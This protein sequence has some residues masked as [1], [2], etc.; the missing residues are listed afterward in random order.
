MEKESSSWRLF[1]NSS[2]KWRFNSIKS[3]SKVNILI[4]ISAQVKKQ[5]IVPFLF[6][7]FFL[8]FIKLK[9]LK[10]LKI[11]WLNQSCVQLYSQIWSQVHHVLIVPKDRGSGLRLKSPIPIVPHPVVY[12]PIMKVMQWSSIVPCLVNQFDINARILIPIINKFWS[13]QIGIQ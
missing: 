12:V 9:Q 6:L 13:L 7:S 3:R 10:D 8:N 2:T 4:S 11:T 5:G 1:D